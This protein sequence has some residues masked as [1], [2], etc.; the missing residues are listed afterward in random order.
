MISL[1]EKEPHKSGI[2]WHRVED[3]DNEDGWHRNDGERRPGKDVNRG[4]IG[5]CRCVL[6]Q[7]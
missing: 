3:E 2:M 7:Y 4:W 5:C 1:A 6:Y